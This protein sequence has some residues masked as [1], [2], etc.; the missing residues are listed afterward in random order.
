MEQE[1]YKNEYF[2]YFKTKHKYQD[3]T[4]PTMEETATN[5]KQ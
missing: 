1:Y 2:C 3:T 4:E 5:T